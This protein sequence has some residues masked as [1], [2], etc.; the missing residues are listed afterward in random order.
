[1]ENMKQLEEQMN[2]EP[3]SPE[4]EF[5]NKGFEVSSVSRI[6]LVEAGFSQDVVALLT[7]EQME[8]IAAKMGEYYTDQ[9]YWG[10]L[11]IAVE[12]TVGISPVRSED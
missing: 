6:D 1:M 12:N 7:D 3:H 8:R 2:E 10:H 5:W 9:G 4:T 11:E